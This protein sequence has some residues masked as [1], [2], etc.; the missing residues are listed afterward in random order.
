[1]I[2]P[3]DLD[4]NSRIALW[5]QKSLAGTLTIEE[6]REAVAYMRAGRKSASEASAAKRRTTK[7]S[8]RSADDMLKDL[9]G[10]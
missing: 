3:D 1:M 2:S 4:L 9:G 8:S 7:A 5:R 10:L 6:Q